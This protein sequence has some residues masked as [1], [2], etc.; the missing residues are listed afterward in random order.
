M[1][2]VVILVESSI[3][4]D[5]VRGRL[6]IEELV[7]SGEVAVCPPVLFEVLRGAR[8]S[9]Y[10][11]WKEALADAH[12]LDEPMPTERFEEAA[13][14][15]IKCRDAGYT[16]GS[17]IDCLIAACAIAHDVTVLH[18]DRDY[19]FIARVVPLKVQRVA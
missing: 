3:C 15:F 6:T 2:G 14:L 1:R 11:T 12:L 18:N 16:I 17:S 9:T 4:I 5:H 19:D 7:R 10:E 13:K 8:A